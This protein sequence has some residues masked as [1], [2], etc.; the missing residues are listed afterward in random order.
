MRKAYIAAVVALFLA[1][2]AFS[3]VRMEKIL[4]EGE[5]ILLALVPVDPRAL[6]MGDYM[7]LEYVVNRAVFAALREAEDGSAPAEAR[8]RRERVASMPEEGTAILRITESPLPGEAVFVRL[9]DG[10]PLDGKEVRLHFRRRGKRILTVASAFYFQEGLAGR[11]ERARYGKFKV[12]ANGRA[13]LVA[14]CD[15]QGRDIAA[16]LATE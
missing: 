12:D 8:T 3:A 16:G 1:G 4:A 14:L 15:E 10:T 7:D 11:Y 5:T 13:L 2:Y 6:L 9:D